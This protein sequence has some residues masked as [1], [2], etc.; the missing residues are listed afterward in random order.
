MESDS[1]DLNGIFITFEGLDGS[2]KTT[3]LRM[4][5][6]MLK[7]RGRS[8]ISTCEPGGTLL[9]KR[10]RELLLDGDMQP[11]PLSELLLFAADRAQHVETLIRPALAKGQ[12]VISDR[13]ADATIAYQGAGRGFPD[14]LIKH[15]VKLATDGLTPDLTFFFDLPVAESLTRTTRRALT[16]TQKDRLDGETVEFHTAVRDAYLKIAKREAKRFRVI[17]ALASPNEIHSQVT[18]FVEPFLTAE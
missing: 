17:N 6:N 4:L 16:G 2:G 18:G 7:A 9:G 12:I 15:L 8:V 5:E 14:R 13:Y 3:Q 10:I 11:Q 1:F